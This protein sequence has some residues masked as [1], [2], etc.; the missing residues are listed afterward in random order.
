VSLGC[1]AEEDTYIDHERRDVHRS[2]S[3]DQAPRP[4]DKLCAFASEERR[5]QAVSMLP[6]AV[7]ALTRFSVC[8]IGDPYS[9]DDEAVWI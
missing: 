7:L 5:R 8:R 4:R 3:A 9:V 1:G 2:A 6:L